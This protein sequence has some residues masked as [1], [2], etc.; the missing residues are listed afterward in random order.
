VEKVPKS[1]A[2]DDDV[3]VEWPPSACRCLFLRDDPAGSLERTAA[4]ASRSRGT[5]CRHRPAPCRPSR[6]ALRSRTGAATNSPPRWPRCRPII[7]PGD[8]CP[9]RG[10]ARRVPDARLPAAQQG[11]DEVAHRHGTRHLLTFAH[12]G[13]GTAASRP[14]G[15]AHGGLPPADGAAGRSLSGRRTRR[16]GCGRV[17]RHL[18]RGGAASSHR[19][20]SNARVCPDGKCTWRADR[21][22]Y[23]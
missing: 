20:T 15:P 22:S 4:G 8:P 23:G 11:V 3:A 5:P 19:R 21:S 9:D 6:Q 13:C 1:P 7:C 12:R 16:N 2:C 17:Q 18:A 10:P 14:R